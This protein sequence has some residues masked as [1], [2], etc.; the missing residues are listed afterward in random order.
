MIVVHDLA[1]GTLVIVGCSG[2][3][4]SLALLALARARDL[5]TVAV[6]VDHG[7]HSRTA[8]PPP[9]RPGIENRHQG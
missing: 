2:G 5:D 4:D 6:Y 1:P 8:I 7:L 3:A 9:R